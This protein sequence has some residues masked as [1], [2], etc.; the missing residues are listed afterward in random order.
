VFTYTF[1]VINVLST[2]YLPSKSES[3]YRANVQ[4][5]CMAV[6]FDAKKKFYGAFNF[7]SVMPG[8]FGVDK[9]NMRV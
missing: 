4:G 1:Q 2:C 8:V 6:V 3:V 5:I 7:C 9:Y